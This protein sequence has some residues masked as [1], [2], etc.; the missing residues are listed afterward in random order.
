MNSIIFLYFIVVIIYSIYSGITE[1][2]HIQKTKCPYCSSKSWCGV[3]YGIEDACPI[4]EQ[5]SFLCD[6]E[7]LYIG[8]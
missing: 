8:D 2:H 4:E 1:R 5:K 7:N 6:R 3:G